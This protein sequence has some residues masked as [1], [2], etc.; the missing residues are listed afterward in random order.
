MES[1]R[2][3]VISRDDR[4]YAFDHAGIPLTVRPSRATVY[5]IAEQMDADYVV[6]GNYSFDGKI[7]TANAQLLDMKKLHLYPE[8]HSSGPLPNLIDLQTTL[9]WELLQEMVAA[10]RYHPRSVPEILHAYPA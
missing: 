7:F 8:V 6:L 2:L 9:A 10:A 1:A 3:H 5:R 4:S